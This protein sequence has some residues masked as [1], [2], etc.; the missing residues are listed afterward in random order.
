LIAKAEG[1]NEALSTRNRVAQERLFAVVKQES[2]RSVIEKRARQEIAALIDEMPQDQKKNIEA[3]RAAMESQVQMLLLPWFRFYLTY[4][5]RPALLKVNCPVLAI[6]GDRDLQVPARENLSAIE[7]A[8]KKGGNKDYSVV[9]LPNLNHLFQTSLTGALSEYARIEE[10]IS[11]VALKT[12]SD[13]ILKRA[14][15]RGDA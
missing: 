2:D 6:N 14:T 5:P 12:I 11:P 13:W 15:K 4:D 8:L 10:T 3:V 1:V 7:Q 9:T